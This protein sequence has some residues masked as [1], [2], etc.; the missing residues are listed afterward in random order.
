M[1]K[2]KKNCK[3]EKDFNSRI[4]KYKKDS[5]KQE[6]VTKAFCNKLFK[7]HPKVIAINITAIMEN[8]FGK[9]FKKSN[10]LFFENKN[11]KSKK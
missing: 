3:K 9:T 5:K 4:E 7:K 10:G 8:E 2:Q 6:E 1:I 11:Y